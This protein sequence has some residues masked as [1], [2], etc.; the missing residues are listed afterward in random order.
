MSEPTAF[1]FHRSGNLSSASDPDDFSWAVPIIANPAMPDGG[2]FI[3][4][5]AVGLS[6]WSVLSVGS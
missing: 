3:W 1:N 6:L 4:C 2:W 5:V